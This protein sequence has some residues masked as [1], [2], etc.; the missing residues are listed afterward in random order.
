MLRGMSTNSDAIDILERLGTKLV[1]ERTGLSPASIYLA[2]RLGIPAR[3][4]VIFSEVCAEEG[5][6]CPRTAFNFAQPRDKDE[7]PTDT[8]AAT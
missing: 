5:V 6:P 8:P 7:A 2:K 1:T 4:Y 3:W